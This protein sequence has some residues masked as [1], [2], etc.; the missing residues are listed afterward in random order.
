M[1]DKLG[2]NF[3]VFVVK[4]KPSNGRSAVAKLLRDKLI[5]QL[6]TQEFVFDSLRDSDTTLHIP[7]H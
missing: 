7:V 6:E 3:T 5:K 2:F 1:S 4:T